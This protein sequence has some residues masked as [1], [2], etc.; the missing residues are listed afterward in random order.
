MVHEGG[1]VIQRFAYDPWGARRD[2]NNWTVKDS[3][4]SFIINRGYTGH[5]HLDAFGIINMNGRVYD[6]ATGMFMSPDPYVQAPKDWL[7]YNRYSYCMGNPFK[8]TDPSG[9]FW[10]FRLITG[11]VGLLFTAVDFI[12]NV[13]G[14]QRIDKAAVN[15]W[16]SG[17]VS[18]WNFGGQIDHAIFGGQNG[19]KNVVGG[20]PGSSGN[21]IYISSGDKVIKFDDLQSMVNYMYNKTNTVNSENPGQVEMVGYQLDNGDGT[22]SFYVLDWSG[23][24]QEKSKNPYNQ[25]LGLTTYDGKVI[26]AE[27]HTHP[28]SY[29]SGNNRSN[30]YDGPSS[31][32][33][34][35]ATELQ[36][37]V[38]SIGPHSV[39]VI[40]PGGIKKD[41]YFD[42]LADRDYKKNDSTSP[43][44]SLNFG[45]TA[46]QTFTTSELR[47][48][49]PFAI[50]ETNE[51]LSNPTYH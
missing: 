46:F 18:M 33:Q 31:Y 41:T 40:K 25:R 20:Q 16:K 7:N 23:N 51:W 4:T 15:A 14:G 21:T 12:T 11:A 26:M 39:S 48:V 30:A 13:I 50:A 3:R 19:D 27:F 49:N 32:D 9:N 24:T 45:P 8:Y 38:Y 42:G 44:S 6:P 34:N 28:A 1:S 35:V 47:N 2:P 22:H 37:P 29:Y 43:N 10:L 17:A 36:V 5:E